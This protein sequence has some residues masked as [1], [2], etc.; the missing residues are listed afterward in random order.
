MIREK[1]V[2]YLGAF[3]IGMENPDKYVK[4]VDNMN[5]KS[6]NP[7]YF[8]K[9]VYTNNYVHYSLWMQWGDKLTKD[10]VKKFNEKG[11]IG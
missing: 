5:A 9:K 11:S 6:S 10:F 3:Q 4:I 8:L 7:V 1:K 2:K